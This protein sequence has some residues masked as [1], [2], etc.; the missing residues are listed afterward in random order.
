M[1]PVRGT[2]WHILEN[3]WEDKE[4]IRTRV[5]EED[6]ASLAARFDTTTGAD[7]KAKKLRDETRIPVS[8]WIDGVLEDPANTDRNDRVR[9]TVLRG[10]APNSQTRLKEM[11]TAMKRLDM[12]VA[13]DPFPTVSAVPHDRTDGVCLLPASTRFEIHG[14]VTASN[15][16]IQWR[17]KIIDPLFESKSDHEIIGLFANKSGVAD[18]LFRNIA[19]DDADTPNIED[20]TREFNRGMWT[21]G[22]TGQRSER[23]R[24]HRA[25]QHTFDRTTLQAI[26]GPAD[27]AA[28]PEQA[29]PT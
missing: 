13:I 4:F 7:G 15:R 21:V 9:A 14:S 28:R 23:I 24:L 20:T 26:G 2:L 5:W 27:T 6:P 3:G 16:S 17:D 19:M 25:N 8:R 1:A 18:R 29:A 11:K 22:H 10:H 12:L